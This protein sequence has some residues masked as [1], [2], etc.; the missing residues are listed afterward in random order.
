MTEP[1]GEGKMSVTVES[2]DGKPSEYRLDFGTEDGF[3]AEEDA[4][5]EGF[6]PRGSADTD[7]QV[8]RPGPDGKIHI[9]DAGLKI[10]AEEPE[11]PDG[12][13]LI[14]VDDGN[15][16]P[17]TYTL[18]N[19]ED[20]ESEPRGLGSQPSAA[21]STPTSRHTGQPAP[22]VSAAGGD[23]GGAP[24]PDVRDTN[25]PTGGEAPAAPSSPEFHSSSEGAVNPGVEVSADSAANVSMESGGDSG[26]SSATTPQAVSGGS[27]GTAFGGGGGGSDDWGSSSDSETRSQSVPSGAR[28]GTAPGGDMPTGM[29]QG[30]GAGGSLAGGMGMMGGMGAMGGGAGGGQGGDQERTSSA[31]RV[32]GNIFEMFSNTVR[33]SGT[34]GDSTED[35]PVRF[36]R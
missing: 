32:E 2:G 26:S 27:G 15:G 8:Y 11:G 16:D 18:G 7:E 33:I 3:P 35:V 4:G 13:T 1:D 10:T 29:S 9:E 20:Q 31:Y 30:G 19:A 34:I 36:S 6:G 17:V 21:D 22:G 12:P 25:V 5:G 14:T 24:E 23:G 28:L